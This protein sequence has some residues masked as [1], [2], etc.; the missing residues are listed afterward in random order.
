MYPFRHAAM[1]QMKNPHRSFCL[2][3]F[4]AV[5]FLFAPFIAIANYHQTPVL[6]NDFY[7][8]CLNTTVYF[9]TRLKMMS[10][11]LH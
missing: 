3:N 9:L 7:S 6:K 2:C 1:P 11:L 8:A 5:H 4:F 10:N